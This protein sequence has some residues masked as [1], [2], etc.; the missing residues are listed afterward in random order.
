M[1]KFS[2]S[3]SLLLDLVCLVY[4]NHMLIGFVTSRT[5]L[6]N[7]CK[8]D[9]AIDLVIIRGSYEPKQE[10]GELN[11]MIPAYMRRL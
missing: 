5:E 2:N 11:K 3:T 7:P 10:V 8:L 4:D 6:P 1:G 9:D